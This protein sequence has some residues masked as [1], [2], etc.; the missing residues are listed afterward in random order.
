MRRPRSERMPV[1]RAGI[2]H[3][4]SRC[5]RKEFLLE[6]AG[7]REWMA[8]VLAAWLEVLAVELLGYALMGNHVHLVLRTRPDVAKG[9]TVSEVRRRWAASRQVADGRPSDLETTVRASGLDGESLAEVRA[10]LSHPGMM[11]RA[12]KEGFA[13]RVN[14]LTG[15]KGHVWESRFHDVALIDAGGVLACLVYVDLNPTRARI[16]QDPQQSTFCSARHREQF[17][18]KAA[19]AALGAKLARLTGH[20]L[21]NGRGEAQGSWGWTSA[22]IAELTTSTAQAL[23]SDWET[24]PTWAEE[25]LPRLGIDRSA[26]MPRMAV[27]G[28]IAGNV[29]GSFVSR[30]TA[31]PASRMASDKTGW[32]GGGGDA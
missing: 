10:V 12:V 31:S 11:L 8:G 5:V 24:F 27:G 30:R 4:T 14:H 25:L 19:D 7:R 15:M 18:R 17:D 9:W 29:I 13:R 28:T 21:L 1:G 20:P 32:F 2:W 16:V 3:V 23:T 6:P 26:W 22:Q